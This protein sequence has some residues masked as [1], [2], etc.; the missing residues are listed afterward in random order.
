MVHLCLATACLW[1]EVVFGMTA[2]ELEDLAIGAARHVARAAD[3]MP[4]SQLCFEYSP[5]TFNVTEPE[6][7]LKVSNSVVSVWDACPDR[8]VTLNLP[9]TVETDSPNIYA[10]Q[11]EWMHRNLVNRDAIILSVHPHND[12]GTAVA[13]AELALMAGADRVEGTLWGNGERTGNVCLATLAL[14]L[15][16]TGIDPQLDF[17]DIDGVRRT[18]EL[19]NQM[20]VHARHPYAGDLVY[21]AFSGTHQ[22][23]ITKGMAALEQLPQSG[24]SE[25]RPRWQVPYLPIDPQDVGRTYEAVIRLNSQSGKG[26]VA[27]V[28]HRQ[29]GLDLPRGLRV[30]FAKVTQ[31]A[32]DQSESELTSRQLW[33]LFRDEYLASRGGLALKD[34]TENRQGN[35]V[36]V[37]AVLF[38]TDGHDMRV[39]GDGG[40]VAAAFVSGL[41]KAG[42]D[43]GLN[44]IF[45]HSLST[46]ADTASAHCATYAEV[47]LGQTTT[48]GVGIESGPSRAA[49]VSIIS[50]FNR[51]ARTR[52]E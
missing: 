17:S 35:R 12:R 39:T 10:D 43:I 28:L 15:F 37:D 45:C 6:F 41:A 30:E 29:Y 42:H 21:T 51:V 26:G 8:P 3:S 44:G 31:Q 7:A 36:R 50:A 14:N 1:R 2:P 32:A 5:E 40:D 48:W 4:R 16:S 49:I 22:D 19:C 9:S 24:A 38:P 11:I 47:R 25:G 52:F 18:V 46:S 27:N 23:A 34:F 33:D 13:A 20:P